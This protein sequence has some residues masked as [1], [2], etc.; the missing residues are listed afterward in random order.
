MWAESRGLSPV[1][2]SNKPASLLLG[3]SHLYKYYFAPRQDPSQLSSHAVPRIHPAPTRIIQDGS[4][5]PGWAGGYL[6]VSTSYLVLLSTIPSGGVHRRFTRPLPRATPEATQEKSPPT[7]P[8]S[9]APGG[10]QA[11]VPFVGFSNRN[12][13]AAG[14]SLRVLI[15]TSYLL[16]GGKAESRR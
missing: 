9:G 12:P 16:F 10:G 2:R 6:H 13:R 14:P 8:T 1:G 4:P 7:C 3:C 15:H 5:S 11:R